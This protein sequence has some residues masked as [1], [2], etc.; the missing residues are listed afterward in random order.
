[1]RLAERR[2]PLQHTSA[3]QRAARLS[4][5]FAPLMV[6]PSVADVAEGEAGLSSQPLP[7]EGTA[8]PASGQRRF[9]ERPAGASSV[10]SPYQHCD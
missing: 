8:A 3:L 7:V 10:L 4:F 9:G 5:H 1:M 6:S 2:R